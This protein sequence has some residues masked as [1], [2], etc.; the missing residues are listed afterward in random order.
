M[1]Q[2]LL[3]P[4]LFQRLDDNFHETSFGDINKDSSKLRTYAYFKTEPGFESYLEMKN[5]SVRQQVT[6][7]R[8]SAHRLCCRNTKD[9]QIAR[10]S[11]TEFEKWLIKSMMDLSNVSNS[12]RRSFRATTMTR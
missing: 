8:L 12:A 11:K 5:I 1:I 10:M 9:V 2:Q 4:K 6:K 3:I 7:F